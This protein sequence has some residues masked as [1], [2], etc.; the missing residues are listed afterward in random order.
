MY[1]VSLH[2]LVCV[3]ADTQK[4][5]VAPSLVFGISPMLPTLSFDSVEVVI[6][7]TPAGA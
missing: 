5:S 1:D 6:E 7:P 2:L 3:N 4:E